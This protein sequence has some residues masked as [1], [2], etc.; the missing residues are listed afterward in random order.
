M[1]F[2]HLA[3]VAGLI[4]GIWLQES[5][6]FLMSLFS[7]PK[8]SRK[9]NYLLLGLGLVLEF[10]SLT[11]IPLTT[12]VLVSC[13]H[14][15]VFKHILITDEKRKYSSAETFGT[16]GILSGCTIAVLFGGIQGKVTQKSYLAV[17]DLYYYSYTACSLL[18]TLY[19]RRKGY[20]SGRIIVETGIPA[21]ISSFAMAAVKVLW[22]SM[23]VYRSFNDLLVMIICIGIAVGTLTVSS[24]FL[25]E[26]EKEHD[27]VI[28]MG[29]YYLWSLCYCLPL[30][31]FISA[32]VNH[33]MLNYVAIAFSCVLIIPGIYLHSFT[34]I[35]YLKAY[36]E[37]KYV[38]MPMEFLV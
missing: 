14:I 21:Q 3:G 34:R 24:S 26:F 33:S 15:A 7:E 37:N 25:T 8:A 9:L 12:F 36:K 17:F 11:V 16:M 18:F 27:L 22:L 38:R 10:T 19:F 29:G 32:G 35:E 5:S 28:I 23:D 4:I 13:A 31:T 20:F 2:T 1:E 30:G 6:H